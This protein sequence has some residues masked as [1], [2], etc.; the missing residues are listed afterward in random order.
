MTGEE[1]KQAAVTAELALA[2][3]C[4]AESQF[5]LNGGFY[6]L[7]RSRAYYAC[8][9]A[10][11][12]VFLAEG[13]AFRKH[14]GLMAAIDTTLVKSGRLPPECSS[15]MR[16]L[17]RSRLQSDYGDTAPTTKGDATAAVADAEQVVSMLRAL[18]AS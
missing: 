8:F 18:L 14:T 6:R 11:T 12:A 15:L 1:A 3:E 2:D 13:E 10:A 9:H 7:V 5:A 16:G 17:Y 4:L